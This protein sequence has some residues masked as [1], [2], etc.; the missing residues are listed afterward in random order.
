MPENTGNL[1][2]TVNAMAYHQESET[3]A[4]SDPGP[5]VVPAVPDLQK[6]RKMS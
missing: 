2:A 6:K 3:I 5:A 4:T 1:P